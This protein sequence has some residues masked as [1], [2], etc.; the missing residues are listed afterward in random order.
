MNL[1]K[2]IRLRR[3]AMVC[4]P[5]PERISGDIFVTK[6]IVGA[7]GNARASACLERR[8]ESLRPDRF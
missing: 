1:S 8:R 5:D 6:M 2:R 3:L 4:A 7:Q